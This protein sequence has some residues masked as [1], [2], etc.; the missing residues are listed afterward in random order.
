MDTETKIDRLA[1]L[2]ALL[3]PQVPI[4]P[5]RAALA[6]RTADE[7]LKAAEKEVY[8]QEHLDV[9]ARVHQRS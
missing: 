1:V 5:E 4:T 9:L 7:L 2:A 8:H 6:V 3:Y